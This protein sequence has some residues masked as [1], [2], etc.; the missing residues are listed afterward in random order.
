MNCGRKLSRIRNEIDDALH[1]ED[2]NLK[3]CPVPF[4]LCYKAEIIRAF[5]ILSTLVLSYFGFF[6]IFWFFLILFFN[7]SEKHC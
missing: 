5:F 4:L 1:E 6:L 2:N 7:I 3:K